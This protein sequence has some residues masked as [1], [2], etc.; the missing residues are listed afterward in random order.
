MVKALTGTM[1]RVGTGNIS[2]NEFRSIFTENNASKVD[3]SPPGKGL[4]LASVNYPEGLY[5]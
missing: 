2:M 3:F 1:L 4:T 5:I